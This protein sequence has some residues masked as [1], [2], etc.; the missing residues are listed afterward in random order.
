M[1]APSRAG[2]TLV[3]KCFVEHAQLTATGNAISLQAPYIEA[4]KFYACMLA[5]SSLGM[6]QEATYYEALYEKRK[7]RLREI[8]LRKLNAVG[9]Q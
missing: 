3:I 7:A 9:R 4:A 8:Y 2:D 1:P 6:V 5:V